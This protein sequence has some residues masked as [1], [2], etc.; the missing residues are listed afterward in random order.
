M[1][2]LTAS[3]EHILNVWDAATPEQLAAGSDW[4]SEAYATA[5]R[6]AAAYG[7]TLEVAAGVIAAT[8]PNNSWVSNVGVAERILFHRSAAYTYRG[9]LGTGLAKARRIL[10]G[11]DPETVLASATYYKVLN[12][13][14]G[15]ITRGRD[16][17]CVDRHAYDVATGTRH[18]DEKHRASEVT[19]LR[20]KVSGK[21]YVEAAQAYESAAAILSERE[22][23]H[24]SGCEVQAVTW[25]VW[26]RRFWSEEAFTVRSAA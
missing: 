24:I 22:G 4:Y 21:R 23:R 15:I 5:E 3:A 2:T 26:R 10:D 25:V 19:P 7:V 13:Y 18:T 8:S 20:P 12:F 17:V 9:Y 16:G 11:E 14:R 1:S 6:F